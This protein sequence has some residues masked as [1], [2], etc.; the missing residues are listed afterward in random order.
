MKMFTGVLLV[1]GLFTS[2]VIGQ[3]KPMMPM[4]KEAMMA[5]RTSYFSSPPPMPPVRVKRDRKWS[6]VPYEDFYGPQPLTEM[7]IPVKMQEKFLA[8]LEGL[9]SMEG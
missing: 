3:D 7:K 1:A 2:S 5:G 4:A 9:D 6:Y 8:A